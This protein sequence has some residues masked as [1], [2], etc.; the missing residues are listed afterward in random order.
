MPVACPAVLCRS[1][2]ALG[3]T[4]ASTSAP[5]QGATATGDVPCSTLSGGLSCTAP[6]AG[7]FTITVSAPGYA[8]S[9]V[10]LTFQPTVPRTACSCGQ[11]AGWEPGTISLTHT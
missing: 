1:P 7:V 4:D 9:R 10:T 2:F 5:V 8:S 3:V 11:C 6:G